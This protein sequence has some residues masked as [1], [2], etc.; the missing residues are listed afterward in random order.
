VGWN[1]IGGN[2]LW[3]RDLHGNEFYYAHLSAFSPAAVNGAQVKA[4]T[5]LGFVGSTGD[6]EG[7]P[8]HLH[9]EIHPASLLF[10]GYDGVINPTAYLNAWQRKQDLRFTGVAGWAPTV[11]ARAS[12]PMPG[13]MLLQSTDIALASGLDPGSLERAMAE[14]PGGDASE[15]L[16]ATAGP[17][18]GPAADPA[19]LEGRSTDRG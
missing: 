4:G 8:Y 9:F 10:L 16:A 3:L 15:T 18:P 14:P 12:A 7:T 6:A 5:V 11:V 17:G 1:K 19:A 13:A 2:R